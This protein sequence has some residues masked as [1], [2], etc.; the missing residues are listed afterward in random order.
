[1]PGDRE[2]PDMAWRSNTASG[3]TR[4]SARSAATARRLR[5]RDLSL[6]LWGV[7]QSLSVQALPPQR[8]LDA[9][10]YNR[11]AAYDLRT[12]KLAWHLG[13]SPRIR[14]A[15]SGDV[16]PGPPLPLGGQ[17]YVLGRVEGGDP[18]AVRRG[19]D[20][21]RGL[22]AAVG[23]GRS[24]TGSPQDPLSGWPA[25]PLVCRRRAGLPDL[26]PLRGGRG[27]GHP[28]LLWGYVYKRSDAGGGKPGLRAS[29]RPL[30]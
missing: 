18:P 28:S 13:G 17:L 24:G 27:L 30:P 20:R 19:Q 14:A 1:M 11:L 9:K 3:A 25:S 7:G 12:G 15:A 22:D 2:A 21:K 10:P 23:R 16:L 29:C 8:P 4:P 6:D 5:H 26:Q